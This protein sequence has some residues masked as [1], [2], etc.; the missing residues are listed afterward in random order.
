MDASFLDDEVIEELLGCPKRITNPGAR[1][2]LQ[3][4]SKQLTYS[5]VSECGSHKFRV[6]LR[7]SDRLEYAFSCGVVLETDGGQI[8]LCRYNGSDHQHRNDI[9]GEKF[10]FRCHIHRTTK[11][12]IDRG[13]KSDKYAEPTDRYEYLPGAVMAMVSDC[14]ITGLKL[15]KFM[16]THE[17]FPEGE[18]DVGQD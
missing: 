11:R 2:S 12:Y 3:K 14:N 9:E 16:Q 15:G 8:S 18:G 4:Q 1:W 6:Y 13:L 5:A 17:L 7:Q 10:A